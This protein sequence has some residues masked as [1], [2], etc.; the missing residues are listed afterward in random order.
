MR[1][2]R[3]RPRRV[4]VT[5]ATGNVGHALLR[6]LARE[7]VAVSGVARRVPRPEDSPAARARWHAVDIARD[8]AAPALREAMDG[9]DAVVHCAWQIQPSHDEA[10]LR[11]TNVD[12]TRRVAQAAVA[13][14]VPHLV[15][16][17]SVGVYAP[18]RGERVG[19][20]WPTTGVASS[21]YSRHKVA[22]ER[23]L[24]E[25][26]AAS[27]GTVVT[28]VRP[29]LVLQADA[30]AEISRYFLG[31]LLPV[32]LLGRLRLPALPLP[33]GLAVPVVH[34]DD[35][36]DALWRALTARLPGGLNVAAD[37]PLGPDDL[38]RAL[39][40]RR[41]APLPLPALRALAAL[42]WRLR[43]QPTSEGWV[44]LA[45]AVPLLSTRRAVLELGWSP[46]VSAQQALADLVAGLQRGTG[47]GTAAMRPRRLLSGRYESTS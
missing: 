4:L 6:R 28:R 13:A 40:A 31:P 24:D 12:G 19:E 46:S 17:S 47:T 9:V 1:D 22:A 44:D 2:A 35:L 42:T 37:P 33:P 18:G 11:A 21:R 38:A 10:R 45:A 5:G 36:A 14:G 39:G 29:G 16:L 15:H 25:A 34:A 32:A 8:W 27:P 23:V 3:A 20:D 7:G 41:A 26:E 30:G 43:L